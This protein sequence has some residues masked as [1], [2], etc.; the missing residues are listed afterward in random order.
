MLQNLHGQAA[1]KKDENWKRLKKLLTNIDYESS[2]FV[3]MNWDEVIE[4]RFLIRRNDAYVDYG[5]NAINARV[6]PDRLCVIPIN[7][8]KGHSLKIVEI[9]GSVNKALLR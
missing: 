4:K 6:S 8:N 2:A 1:K 7:E 9:H 3:S 5:C